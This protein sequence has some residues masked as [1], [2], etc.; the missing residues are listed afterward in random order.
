MESLAAWREAILF[1]NL[2]GRVD[3]LPGF[4]LLWIEYMLWTVQFIKFD[5]GGQRY[6]PPAFFGV[7]FCA[8]F[9]RW[10]WMGHK[11]VRRRRPYS[12]SP[13]AMRKLNGGSGWLWFPYR[14]W[15]WRRSLSIWRRLRILLRGRRNSLIS[16]WRWRWARR[17]VCYQL[18]NRVQY[19]HSSQK[20]RSRLLIVHSI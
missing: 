11:L 9:M 3:R 7:F 4:F 15:R 10:V 18:G 20:Y 19:Y 17:L 12:P 1:F 8:W 16:L 13:Q 6:F 5:N 2:C 14:R